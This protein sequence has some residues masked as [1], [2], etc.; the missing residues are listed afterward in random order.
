MS[1][2]GAGLL[3]ILMLAG[4]AARS[5]A[6]TLF[7]ASGSG[8]SASARFEFATTSSG[9]KRQLT[10]LLTNTDNATGTSGGSNLFPDVTAEV[11]TGLFFNLGTSTTTFTPIS[12]TL[13]TGASIVQGN[14]CDVSGANCGSSQKNVGGEWSYAPGGLSSLTQTTT[15]GIGSSAYLNKNN[16]AGNLGGSNLDKSGAS[17]TTA[18][19]GVNFGIVPDGWAANSGDSTLDNVPLIEGT[20]KFVLSIPDTLK[21][22]DLKNVYF[23]YGGD[24]KENKL[25]GVKSSV[26]VPE[27]AML[28]MFGLALAGV[29]YRLRRRRS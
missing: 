20:V 28:S 22:V 18:L 4:G 25:L 17:S 2:L 6:T 16:S 15:Q 13:E 19:G 9:G 10:I 23:T 7:T 24:T 12:A 8:L 3:T 11:L 29:G 1:R 5:E 21:E 14:Q 26:A 27:P